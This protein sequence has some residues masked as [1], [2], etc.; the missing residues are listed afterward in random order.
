MSGPDVDIICQAFGITPVQHER[1]PF[2]NGLI[3]HTYLLKDRQGDND[4]L[5]QRVNTAVFIKPQLI[6][7]NNYLAG[8][9]LRSHYPAYPFMGGRKTVDGKDLF[10][11]PATG[12]WR[13]FRFFCDTVGFSRATSPD[14][15]YG[16]AQQYGRLVHYLDGAYVGAF[17]E[18]IPG[19]H[20]LVARYGTF[21][22]SIE[23]GQPERRSKADSLIKFFKEHAGIVDT[24]R[25]MATSREVHT[26]I[27][28]N[29]AKMNNVLFDAA[30][31]QAKYVVDLD[32]LMPGKALFDLGDMI[33]TFISPAAEDDPDPTSCHVNTELFDAVVEGW[34][35]EMGPLLSELEKE[36]L[37]W[38]GQMLMYEQ[39]IRFLTDYLDGDAYY[40][41]QHPEHN[42]DRATNQMHLL[43]TYL[44]M[45][46]E[47]KR[48]VK[49]LIN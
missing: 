42:L 8:E 33:R 43:R 18:V 16:A 19:F 32:T 41:T 29:D 17:Q 34:L 23:K 36:L 7:Y 28:H 37:V 5:L 31:G 45:E 3:N 9:H 47:L 4:W 12:T 40:K 27:T 11:D 24:Y 14:Q 20:D 2:G 22:A 25:T 1:I 35:S 13:I 48:R 15:A 30:T 21:L 26:R 10:V 46:D 49:P 38:S 6:A 39:G 44:A